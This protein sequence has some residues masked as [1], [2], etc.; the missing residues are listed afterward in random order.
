MAT[1]DGKSVRV[2]VTEEIMVRLLTAGQV[3]AA[4]LR[5]LD[6]ES[7]QCLRRLCLESCVKSRNRADHP[8]LR[9]CDRCLEEKNRKLMVDAG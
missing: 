6:C 3:C 1:V 7:K 9:D 4:D 5:C 2:E 8:R